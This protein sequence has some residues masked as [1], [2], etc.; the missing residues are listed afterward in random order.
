M[1]DADANMDEGS[2]FRP[3]KRRK[4]LRKR[5]DVEGSESALAPFRPPE[6][7]AI[8]SDVESHAINQEPHGGKEISVAE[9]MRLRKLNR[10]RKGGIEFSTT[11]SKLHDA[12]PSI[13]T[14]ALRDAEEQ[15]FTAIAD[16]FTPHSGQVVDVD[17]HMYVLSKD[18]CPSDLHGNRG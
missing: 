2:S 7:S 14:L 1:T 4:F 16:R 10:S 6:V 3:A 11:T 8:Q 17:K 12:T 13:T 5:Q 15:R 9:I 18:V